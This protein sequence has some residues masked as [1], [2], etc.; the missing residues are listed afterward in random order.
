M[1]E[2]VETKKPVLYVIFNIVVVTGVLPQ[3]DR[4]DGLAAAM[5]VLQLND[6]GKDQW[7]AGQTCVLALSLKRHITYNTRRKQKQ[8]RMKSGEGI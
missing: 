8:K 3:S 2:P 5:Y 6:A 1:C 7:K 4:A